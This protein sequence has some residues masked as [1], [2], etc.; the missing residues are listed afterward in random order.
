MSKSLFSEFQPV[1]KQTWIDKITADLK[2]KPF[3]SILKTN[4]AG[5]KHG[6][7]FAS[8]DLSNLHFL[9]TGPGAFPFT[10]GYRHQNN[11]WDIAQRINLTL[12]EK[13]ANR[14]ALSALMGGA[15]S[16]HFINGFEDLNFNELLKDIHLD[17][18]SVHFDFHCGPHFL[19][20]FDSFLGATDRSAIRG[21][22]GNDPLHTEEKTFFDV[23]K[24]AA[25]FPKF[26]QITIHGSTFNNLGANPVEEI[27][28]SLSLA[29][30]YFQ[31][32]FEAGLSADDLAPYIRFQLGVGPDYFT[33]IA[34]FRAFRYLYSMM[35]SAYNPKNVCTS[36]TIVHAITTTSN[37]SA[38]DRHTN[39]LR[40]G[41]EA[42]SAVMGGIQ[43]LTVVPFDATIGESDDFSDRMARNIQLMLKHESY[44][45]EV[46]DPAAGSYYLEW[47]TAELI[48]KAWKLFTEFESEG[49]FIAIR[50]KGI[51]ENTLNTSAEKRK[52]NVASRREILLGVNQ[53]PNQMETPIF[54]ENYDNSLHLSAPFEALRK[55]TNA[56]FTPTV[57]LLQTGNPAM[58]KARAMFAFNF[59]GC[60]G[61]NIVQT[62]DITDLHQ[63][64]EKAKELNAH[65]T[66]LCGSDDDYAEVAASFAENVKSFSLPV[67]AGNPGDKADEWTSAGM[68]AFIHMKTNVLQTLQAF[69][70]NL[71]N[72]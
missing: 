32:A 45:N 21:S 70:K 31:Q 4:S 58:R 48:D 13:E 63:G 25:S 53:F 69:Q 55:E 24:L 71:F 37:L 7:A 19:Q 50:N 27:A 5:I 49:G 22:F 68:H 2:G 35:T 39:L 56:H 20:A 43:T 66:V 54:P 33:E 17:Y 38:L 11:D 28:L 3:D 34:K 67:L 46:V 62:D 15:N 26:H 65:I 44:L 47:M 12:G 16:L 41:T 1:S 52:N 40:T 6:P 59:F 42:M 8:E 64:I 30:E 57:Y 60:A 36:A 9:K 29:N 72:A 51:L 23:A 61:F 14:R 10:R 18:I